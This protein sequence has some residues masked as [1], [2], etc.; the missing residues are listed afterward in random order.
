MKVISVMIVL[1][2]YG[3][4]GAGTVLASST[5]PQVYEQPQ[6]ELHLPIRLQAVPQVLV[7]R[8]QIR[9]QPMILEQ[10]TDHRRNCEMLVIVPEM[11]RMPEE[12]RGQCP[13]RGPALP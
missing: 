3:S 5:R 6:M 8:G 2:L 9:S 13:F 10:S 1:A 12:L 7:T 4:A 11:E